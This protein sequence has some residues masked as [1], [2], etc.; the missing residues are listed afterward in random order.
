MVN[1]KLKQYIEENIYKE[2]DKNE[3]GHGIKHINS[4]V[5]RALNIAKKYDLNEDIV[6]TIASY[7]DIGHHIDAKNHEKISAKIFLE[8][9]NIKSFFD[10]KTIK[11]IKEA[12]EDHRASSKEEPRSIYGKVI[13]LA[14]KST[15]INETLLRTHYYTKKHYPNYT[16]DM[17]V[18]RAYLHLNE[19]YGKLGYAKQYLRDE[20]YEKFIKNLQSLLEDKD[21]FYKKY[22]EVMEG[23][24]EKI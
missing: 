17:E 3:E 12:I 23:K 2:Y 20:E 11:L 10:S 16:F 9:E 21:L 19:K 13:T 1:S 6:Y 4:V 18:E 24:R 14:D 7:H 8:D 22:E 5:K 15:D